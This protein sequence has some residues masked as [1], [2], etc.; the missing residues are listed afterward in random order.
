MTN[1]LTRS[2]RHIRE[3]IQMHLIP[4][5]TMV[6][7]SLV[8]SMHVKRRQIKIDGVKPDTKRMKTT[9]VSCLVPERDTCNYGLENNE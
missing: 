2:T 5:Y 1:P 9:D 8:A 4:L 6:K 7:E 3:N